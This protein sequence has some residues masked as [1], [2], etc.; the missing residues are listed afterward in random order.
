VGTSRRALLPTAFAA[1]LVMVLLAAGGIAV[2]RQIHDAF[3]ATQN[4]QTARNLAG[5]SVKYQLDE[6]T[7]VRGLA[8]TGDPHFLEPYNTAKAQ[9]RPSLDEFTAALAAVDLSDQFGS[10]SKARALSDT[11]SRTVAQPIIADPKK[12]ADLVQRR[13]KDL[14]DAYRKDIESIV[15]VIKTRN[16][17]V[18]EQVGWAIDRI[19]VFIGVVIALLLIGTLIYGAQQVRIAKRLEAEEQRA[20]AERR[21]LAETQA[22]YLAE[23][24]IA[25]TLQ[26]A[27]SQRP[28]PSLP[29]LRFSATYVPA[30]EDTKVG[31][32]WYDALELPSE[33]V[34][35]AIG[36]VTGHGIEAAVTMNRTR[37]S[38]ISAALANADPAALLARVNQ[39]VVEQDGPLVTAIAG[40]ADPAT[41]EFVYAIAGHP[42]PVLIE[43]GR[44]PRLLEFGSLPLGALATTEY[45]TRRIQTVPGAT[46]VLY[47]DGAVEHSHNILEGE[48]LLLSIAAEA[49][50]R[51]SADPAAFIHESIFSS[52][53]VG[54]DVA[55][56]TVGFAADPARESTVPA[57]R[58]RSMRGSVESRYSGTSGAIARGRVRAGMPGSRAS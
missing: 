58:E 17:A 56:L 55:I 38:L 51:Q 44:A 1:L 45:R 37:Q 10:L 8:A 43:P 6:E 4:L 14:M 42:P 21:K 46:L 16:E 2:R 24:R 32:D 41:F 26:D 52:R 19:N 29:A 11:W 13:G 3:Q 47:T 34:L 50:A 31:G 49:A 15:R 39:D 7:E 28:L 20:E 12:N 5:D 25:D 30:S 36:D 40:F 18:G 57:L 53:Q 9:L 27:F 23:K 35:F 33:R 22:A 54:D 48:S